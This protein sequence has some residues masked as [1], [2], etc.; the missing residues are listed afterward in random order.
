MPQDKFHVL[1]DKL[2]Y[3]FHNVEL[4]QVALTHSSWCA[5]NAG[6]PSNER[7][8]FL[9]DAVL[10]M[11]VT[12]YIYNQYPDLSEGKLSQLRALVVSSSSLSRL[13]EEIGVGSCLRLGKGQMASDNAIP[14]SML[15]D[16]MEAIIG[17]TFLDGGW[18]AAEDLILRLLGSRIEENSKRNNEDAK[19]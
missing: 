3:K 17:A 10:G 1:S 13:A 4:L 5:E 16:A 14:P 11:A 18:E 19:S 9:G 12:R 6:S 7:L 15:E 2:Q 8:E